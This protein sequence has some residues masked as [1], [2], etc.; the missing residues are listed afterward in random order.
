MKTQPKFYRVNSG[1]H[2]WLSAAADPQSCDSP[3]GKT[4]AVIKLT[5][6]RKRAAVFV[7][8]AARRHLEHVQANFPAATLEPATF[9]D[10]INAPVSAFDPP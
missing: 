9:D 7:E 1:Y 10:W 6:S 3:P 5:I 8:S 2:G 4:Y